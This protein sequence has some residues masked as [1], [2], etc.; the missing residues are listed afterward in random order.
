MLSFAKKPNTYR[1]LLSRNAALCLALLIVVV[2]CDDDDDDGNGFGINDPGDIEQQCTGRLLNGTARQCDGWIDCPNG[3]D[4]LGCDVNLPSEPS[5]TDDWTD[6]PSGQDELGCGADS[7]SDPDQTDQEI[8]RYGTTQNQL[9]V[10]PFGCDALGPTA[11]A[12][13]TDLFRTWAQGPTYICPISIWNPVANYCGWSCTNNGCYCPVDDSIFFDWYLFNQLSQSGLGDA[14]PI[15]FLAHEWGHRLQTA[16][17]FA[18]G[19]AQFSIQVELQADCISGAYFG[20]RWAAHEINE[21]EVQQG[22]QLF[23]LLGDP[24]G[25]PWFSSGAHGTPDMRISQFIHGASSMR[26]YASESC[27]TTAGHLN[28]LWSICPLPY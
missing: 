8:C 19:S 20:L 10:V 26:A 23:G 7:P 15:A 11:V 24:D 2:G 17:G 5:P 25:I 18:N 16:R 12:Y 27:N 9:P 14:A 22:S 1:M 4:E 13:A 28:A 21:Y 3:E 6:C